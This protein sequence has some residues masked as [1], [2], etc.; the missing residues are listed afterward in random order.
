[1]AIIEQ[2]PITMAY[3]N[4]PASKGIQAIASKLM[5]NEDNDNTPKEGIARVFLDFIKS[6]RKSKM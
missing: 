4:S 5:Q 6:R 2:K 3:P 1:M